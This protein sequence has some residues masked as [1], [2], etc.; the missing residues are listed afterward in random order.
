[1]I[2]ILISLVLSLSAHAQ[3]ID[4]LSGIDAT[5]Q[6]SAMVQDLR[7]LMKAKG[8][9]SKSTLAKLK[10]SALDY[11]D[12][13]LSSSFYFKQ[14]LAETSDLLLNDLKYQT[15]VA[16]DP[17]MTVEDLKKIQAARN[18][19]IT[20]AAIQ[21]KMGA[22]QL[23]G[24]IMFKFAKA[25]GEAPGA[26]LSPAEIE[27]AQLISNYLAQGPNAKESILQILGEVHDLQLFA[28]RVR[29]VNLTSGKDKTKRSDAVGFDEKLALSLSMLVSVRSKQDEAFVRLQNG[30]VDYFSE[31]K[32]VLG[33]RLGDIKGSRA[34]P[35][36]SLFARLQLT[37]KAISLA[38][39][40]KVEESQTEAY[41]LRYFLECNIFDDLKSEQEFIEK[42]LARIQGALPYLESRLAGALRANLL[43]SKLSRSQQDFLL[44]MFV[45]MIADDIPTIKQI[46]AL[47]KHAM[48]DPKLV[49]AW[50]YYRQI[51]RDLDLLRETLTEE[52]AKDIAREKDED[53]IRT[54]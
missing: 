49:G 10:A 47:Q 18:V 32:R 51:Q 13:A 19:D 8:E 40:L 34:E 26:A 52:R 27:A 1:M 20:I 43:V 48:Q 21:K 12:P 4:R 45:Q 44:D 11:G 24:E 42:R 28:G 50:V 9:M 29:V 36:R 37:D 41:R 2:N 22:E 35:S 3:S 7:T 17:T 54:K 31:Q 15:P 38:D 46:E 25:K 6:R 33:R 5:S 16:I 14:M 39:I 30:L 53:A 23:L